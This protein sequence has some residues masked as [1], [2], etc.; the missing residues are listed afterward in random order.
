MSKDMQN[1]GEWLYPFQ[2]FY[3]L[4]RVIYLNEIGV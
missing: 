2:N 1:M 4:Y 3:Y